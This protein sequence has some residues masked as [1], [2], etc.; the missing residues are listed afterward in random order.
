MKN[1]IK[2]LQDFQILLAYAESLGI[3]IN[4][5]N[6]EISCFAN[7]FNAININVDEIEKKIVP[8]LS[9][10]FKNVALERIMV[11][12]FLHEIGHAIQSRNDLLNDSNDIFLALTLEKQ[13]NQIAQLIGDKL[14]IEYDKEIMELPFNNDIKE[15]HFQL[16]ESSKNLRI[17]KR[18]T[19]IID[20]LD[21]GGLND[22]ISFN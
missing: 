21:L 19:F 1:D 4:F 10:K 17:L 16:K 14:N 7:G 6:K 11:N 8:I 3:F 22:W 13:A 2:A 12:V 9:K 15:L 18:N 5:S 20:K